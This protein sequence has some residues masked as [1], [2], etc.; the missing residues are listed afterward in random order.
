MSTV[1][2]R[3]RWPWVVLAAVLVLV[4]GPL[5][6]RFRPLN[7]TEKR[8]VGRWQSTFVDGSIYEFRPDR[9]W[10]HSLFGERGSWTAANGEIS[11]RLDPSSPPL[12]V[13]PWLGRL[14]TFITRLDPSR[15][16]IILD[17]PDLLL[18]NR[19]RLVRLLDQPLYAD[20]PVSP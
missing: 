17:G 11:F 2:R 14:K 8:L 7:A 15:V 9:R 13:Q 1:G 5:A 20:L 12:T 19:D 10:K 18:M 16:T 6:W 4:G 3:R